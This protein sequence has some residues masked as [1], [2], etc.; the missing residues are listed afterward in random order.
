M[1]IE[2]LK[3]KLVKTGL[4]AEIYKD[5]ISVTYTKEKPAMGTTLNG[6]EMQMGKRIIKVNKQGL[7]GCFISFAL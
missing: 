4:K 6:L 7:N 3:N 5:C 2:Q 1:T